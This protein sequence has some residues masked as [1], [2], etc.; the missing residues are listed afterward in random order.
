MAASARPAM[1]SP[2]L[3]IMPPS[4]LLSGHVLV[5]KPYP[6]LRDMPFAGI[7]SAIRRGRLRQEFARL[8][9]GSLGFRP[10][11]MLVEPRDDLD[12][13]AAAIA[14]VGPVHE[15]FVP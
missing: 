5:A 11:Q 10:A 6:L 1:S 4:Q 8:D 2:R 14:V 15:D 7:V 9:C 3:P 12:G 13:V